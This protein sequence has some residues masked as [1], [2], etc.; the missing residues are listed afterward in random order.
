MRPVESGKNLE[1]K[2]QKVYREV[3]AVE[4]CFV[5]IPRPKIELV[6]LPSLDS[7]TDSVHG[8]CSTVSL[9]LWQAH[10]PGTHR[11]TPFFFIST[12]AISFP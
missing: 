8:S 2:E 11:G 12:R 10:G 1:N 9:A 4:S 3:Q 7:P 5:I 6:F